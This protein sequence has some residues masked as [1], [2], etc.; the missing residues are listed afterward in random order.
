[1]DRRGI[2][3]ASF[4]MCL[5]LPAVLGQLKTSEKQ[6]LLDLHNELRGTAG[7]ANIVQSVSMYIFYVQNVSMYILLAS[8]D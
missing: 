3:F 6:Y 2:F 7:G 4:Y 5:F 8:I 1:M